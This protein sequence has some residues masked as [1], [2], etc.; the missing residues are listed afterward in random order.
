[1]VAI[2]AAIQRGH[3]GD[4]AGARD[5]LERLWGQTGDAL[6]RV[7]IAH[8]VADLQESVADE[9]SWDERAL[10]VV[11]ELTDERAQ[12]YD[13][14]FQVRAFK[15]SL[16]LNLAD[17]HRRLGHVSEAWHHVALA[18]A[19]IDLLPDDDYGRLVRTGMEKI[20]RALEEGSIE[21][22]VP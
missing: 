12:Q 14:S 19:D 3:A 13:K 21:P 18:Q 11:A 7:T 1:M 17:A 2:T 9:L 16:H 5:E 8:F 20:R 6:H 15:P 10:A 4:R 22:L